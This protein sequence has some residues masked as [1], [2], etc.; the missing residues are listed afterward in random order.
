MDIHMVPAVFAR[1]TKAGRRKNECAE[2]IIY[3]TADG[4]T[5]IEVELRGE[6]VWLSLDQIAEFFQRDKST[7]SR[8]IKKNAFTETCDAGAGI[9]APF[10]VK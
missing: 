1:N 3:Q 7:V 5:K 4:L 2:I 10:V 6:T 8:H 9:P